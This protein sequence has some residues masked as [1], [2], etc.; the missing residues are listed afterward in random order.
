[1]SAD[2][3]EPTIDPRT[4]GA[5][6]AMP[7]V[8][9]WAGGSTV[10]HVRAA[11]EDSWG[12]GEGRLFA[13]ADGIASIP[14]GALASHAAISEILQVDPRDGWIPAIRRI[15]ERVRGRCLAEGFADAGTTLLA[16]VFERRRCVTVNVGDSR[17]YR[18]RGD[19]VERLTE[20]HTLATLRRREG[21]APSD[22][23]PRGKPG[24]LASFIGYED[25]HFLIDVGT[26]DLEP[27]DHIIL[28]TDGVYRQVD[29]D[30]FRR[31]VEVGTPADA[32]ADL[33]STANATGGRDNATV[34]VV[35]LSSGS[36][37][38]DPGLG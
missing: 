7:V 9:D 16:A 15:N 5:V 25:D 28:C 23:D 11:N 2:I 4:G 20:D 35:R 31:S 37:S 27:G 18:L 22:A 10:G 19:R 3:D 13:V 8:A 32:V 33:L 36:E 30:D 14:G 24:W 34:I 12:H 1:M 6:T 26:A 29:D 21:L 38:L 17:A